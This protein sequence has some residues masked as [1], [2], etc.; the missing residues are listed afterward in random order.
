MDQPLALVVPVFNEESRVEEFG[1]ELLAHAV[2]LPAGSELVFVDDGSTDRTVERLSSL[3]DVRVLRR[4]HQGKGAAVIR[5]L[6]E[7]L[8]DIC[9]IQDADLEYDPRDFPG[10]IH[11]ILTHGADAVYGSRFLGSHRVFLYWH[12]MAN[13]FLTLVTNVLTNLNLSD[14]E[15]GYKVFRADVVR[16]LT[17]TSERFG[18]E[19][20]LTIKAARL[21]V[22]IY[23]VPI[24]YHG[25]TYAEGKKITWRD[26]VS[27]IVHIVRYR[28][29][30]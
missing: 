3:G 19:P 16:R 25:R 17:L 9:I 23:E 11:P 7:A 21:G 6:S 24:R 10:M 28:F 5:A 1:A 13:K 27:A 12:Y 14:M 18:I 15:V 30:A 22:R 26:G 4:P 8:G 2:S 29:F 20:E